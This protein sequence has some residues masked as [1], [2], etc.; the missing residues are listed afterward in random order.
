M[1]IYLSTWFY[2]DSRVEGYLSPTVY[3]IH[4]LLGIWKYNFK[5][6]LYYA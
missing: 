6:T 1:P 4:L 3:F 5:L 2:L